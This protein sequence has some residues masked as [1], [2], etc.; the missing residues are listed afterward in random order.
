MSNPP[1]TGFGAGSSACEGQGGGTCAPSSGTRLD[2]PV[3]L[4]EGGSVVFTLSATVLSGFFGELSSSAPVDVLELDD[5]DDAA[6]V[7]IRS[8]KIFRDRF[9]LD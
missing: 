5:G 2:E 3:D 4:P 8:V 9:E 1:P 7:S 6:S